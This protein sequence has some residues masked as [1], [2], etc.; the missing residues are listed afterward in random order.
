MM[1]RDS[2]SIFWA[3]RLTFVFLLFYF[4]LFLTAQKD[5]HYYSMSTVIVIELI[6]LLPQRHL[7]YCWSHI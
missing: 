6:A 7:F 4:A 5:V 2:D 1:N 3:T